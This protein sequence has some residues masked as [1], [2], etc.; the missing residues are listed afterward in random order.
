M[1][2]SEELA[3]LDGFIASL[4]ADTYLSPWLREVRGEVERMIRCDIFPDV[5]LA[6]VAARCLQRR[7]DLEKLEAETKDRISRHGDYIIAAAKKK[8]AD[9]SAAAERDSERTRSYLADSLRRLRS[10]LAELG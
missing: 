9:I 8:A 10:T 7:H 3:A 1:T 5:S 2:K 4:P 6:E